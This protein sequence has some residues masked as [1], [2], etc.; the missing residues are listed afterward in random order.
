MS[1]RLTVKA[2]MDE[3]DTKKREARLKAR[4]ERTVDFRALRLELVTKFEELTALGPNQKSTSREKARKNIMNGIKAMM[5][6]TNCN[7]TM[8]RD[9]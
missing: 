2:V 6:L 4:S 1:K 3:C 7:Q 9:L 5:T 8:A